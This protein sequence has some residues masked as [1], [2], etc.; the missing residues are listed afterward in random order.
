MKKCN[1]KFRW[2]IDKYGQQLKPWE[3]LIKLHVAVLAE[4]KEIIYS[5]SKQNG[6]NNRD[7]VYEREPARLLQI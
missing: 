6:G 3:C 5:Y 7:I 4:Q 2:M 1:K